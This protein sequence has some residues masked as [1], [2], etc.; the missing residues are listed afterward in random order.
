MSSGARI[1][2]E[3]NQHTRSGNHRNAVRVLRNRSPERLRWRQA[4]AQVSEVAGSLRG[5]SRMRIEEPTREIVLDLNDRIL[6]REA[7]LDATG[8]VR[9]EAY[10]VMY[11][12]GEPSVGHAACLLPD[13]RRTWGR[14]TDREAARAM[15]LDE[16]CGRP[17]RLADGGALEISR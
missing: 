12:D 9:I 2:D 17:G 11:E 1:T 8:D 13:G 6:R 14:V 7:V 15:T 4:V 16:F 10:T 3:V 5:V